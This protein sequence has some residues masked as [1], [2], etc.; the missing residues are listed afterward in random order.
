[1]GFV[2]LIRVAG[3]TMEKLTALD[4]RQKLPSAMYFNVV[5]Y[6]LAPSLFAPLPIVGPLIAL[7]WIVVLWMIGAKKRLQAAWAASIIGPMVT[8]IV[9]FAIA[10]GVYYVGGFAYG[11]AMGD[12]V[13]KIVAPSHGR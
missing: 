3:M 13:T 4:V 11:M 9:M 7:G 5:A 12:T 1:G 2:L 6:C 10:G 8:G